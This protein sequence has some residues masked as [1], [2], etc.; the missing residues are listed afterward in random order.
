MQ[1]NNKA[2]TGIVAFNCDATHVIL[3]ETPPK[4]YSLKSVNKEEEKK[5]LHGNLSFTKG[6]VKPQDLNAQSTAAREFQEECGLTVNL[7]DFVETKTMLKEIKERT[8]NL[9]V[10][11]FIAGL[12][13]DSAIDLQHKFT[14]DDPDE[15]VAVRWFSMKE[16][17]DTPYFLPRRKQVLWKAKEIYLAEK[18]E[19]RLLDGND[20]VPFGA[21]E[22][23]LL[24]SS[25]SPMQDDCLMWCDI[26]ANLAHKYFKKDVE[27]VIEYASVQHGVKFMLL[28]STNFKNYCDNLNL[29]DSHEKLI[30]QT[31]RVVLNTTLGI[32][33]CDV[34]KQFASS[35]KS[36][37]IQ[38]RQYLE[39]C[40]SGQDASK[41][42]KFA[43]PVKA[44]GE[45]GLDY[46][47]MKSS[48]QEQLDC[49]EMQLR[50]ACEFQLPLFLHEREA[51]DDFVA[52]LEKYLDKLKPNSTVVHCF[53]GT[54]KEMLKYLEM[55][56]FIGITGFIAKEERGKALR[57]FVDKIPLNRLLLETDSPF[58][59]PDNAKPFLMLETRNEP[60]TIPLVA[61]CILQCY[62]NN[63]KKGKTI[64]LKQLSEITTQNARRVFNL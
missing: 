22:S 49:F 46:F 59:S 52:L 3:V 10:Q 50:L 2:C 47:R 62:N 28:T 1:K 4:K 9:S 19:Q 43:S 14:W 13:K 5:E 42:T 27:K 40:G 11:Y 31:H 18:L 15:I 6:G 24:S 56:F 26:G 33:P 38:F 16:V 48:K 17:E 41:E 39:H 23:L 57:G 64:T 45:C 29:V 44:I 7:F 36:I 58:M 55:G 35:E 20:F 8:G 12:K 51:H 30:S 37:E 60:C 32:H 63:R 34:P 53:G 21:K 54:E 61:K 25:I